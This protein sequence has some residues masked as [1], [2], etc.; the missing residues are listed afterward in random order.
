MRQSSN[1][2]SKAHDYNKIGANEGKN[3]PNRTRQ[4]IS[5]F[6]SGSFRS[7]SS[8][9]LKLILK[10]RSIL[11]VGPSSAGKTLFL[12]SLVRTCEV[13][14][15]RKLKK[16]S[17]LDLKSLPNLTASTFPT[18][19]VEQS[20]CTYDSLP[21]SIREVGSSLAPMWPSYFDSSSTVF[22]LLDCSSLTR[23]SVAKVELGNIIDAL[24]KGGSKNV[25]PVAIIL[26]KVDLSSPAQIA[27]LNK[28]LRLAEL[29]EKYATFAG[30]AQ[31]EVA[32]VFELSALTGLN[33]DKVLD[34]VRR[35][36]G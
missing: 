36:G 30:K 1:A 12:K 2:I 13:F 23:A 7:S 4:V 8:S 32:K 17:A 35:G 26:N 14:T 22:F 21:L 6:L 24:M 19:G 3:N 27:A 15:L 18:V 33:V 31:E 11:L 25:K 10:A 28:Y 9:A 16:N 29:C 5:S 20:S 34:W